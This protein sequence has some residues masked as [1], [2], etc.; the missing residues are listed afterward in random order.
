MFVRSWAID[1]RYQ[2]QAQK[3]F[4]QDAQV[5]LA[6]M[7]QD[8]PNLWDMHTLIVHPSYENLAQS[9]GFQKTNVDPK[10]PI[11]WMYQSVDRFL[12]LNIKQIAKRLAKS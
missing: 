5:T 12:A 8:F 3:S 11:Y 9:L 2:K 10:L 1:S 7:Q 6:V 4:L